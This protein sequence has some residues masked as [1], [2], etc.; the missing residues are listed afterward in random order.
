MGSGKTWPCE[1]CGRL[2]AASQ[3][4]R[5]LSACKA[6]PLPEELVKVWRDNPDYRLSDLKERYGA[7]IS[8]VR[9]RLYEG[10]LTKEEMRARQAANGNRKSEKKKP[11]GARCVKCEALIDTSG[12]Y[13]DYCARPSTYRDLEGDDYDGQTNWNIR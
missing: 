3:R 5:H 7:S 8:F 10:G 2:V 12:P 13:C 6:V 1:R 11:W 9:S 4:T